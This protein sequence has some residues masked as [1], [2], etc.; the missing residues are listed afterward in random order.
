MQHD[1]N[2][3]HGDQKSKGPD[4]RTAAD[5]IDKDDPHKVKKLAN[6]AKDSDVASTAEE[7]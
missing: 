5:D 3:R 6:A 4:T 2:D 1:S 7:E